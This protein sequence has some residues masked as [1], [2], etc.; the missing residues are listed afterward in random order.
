M[1]NHKGSK[2]PFSS[3]TSPLPQPE[4]DAQVRMKEQG[5]TSPQ[6]TNYKAS[7]AQ[8]LLEE[9]PLYLVLMISASVGLLFQLQQ[10]TALLS[11]PNKLQDSLTHREILKT[12]HHYW[13]LFL[14]ELKHQNR[15]NMTD[16]ICTT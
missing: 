2:G 12:S 11:D 16:V 5:N 6:L 4:V 3:V 9:L 14:P 7:A 13:E 8:E 1:D 15:S 10:R